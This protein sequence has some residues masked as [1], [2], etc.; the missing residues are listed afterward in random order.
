MS[1]LQP[2]PGFDWM[3]V[4]WGGPDEPRTEHCSYCGAELPDEDDG[5]IPLILSN[6]AGWVAEFCD[7][8][9]W[10]WWGI[11]RVDDERE[12]ARTL[13]PRAQ[14]EPAPGLDPGEPDLGPCCICESTENV[15]NVIM[16]DRRGAVPGHGWG[17]VVC[18]LP[19]DGASAVL[20]DAC[21]P[22]W[23]TDESL[24]KIACRGYPKSDGRIPIAELPPGP[25]DHDTARHESGLG[26][27]D[28]AS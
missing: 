18:G 2:K 26:R 7:K 24:L 4:Q 17:C 22:R 13:E 11:E 3:L 8:C 27:I 15:H 21:L 5:F 12:V 20:C 19:S 25:F 10:Q 6:E 1:T 16:L 14:P 28:A 23:Q 9:Q